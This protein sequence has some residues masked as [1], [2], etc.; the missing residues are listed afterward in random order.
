MNRSHLRA[1]ARTNGRGEQYALAGR[2]W[3]ATL[4]MIMPFLILL[5]ILSIYKNGV[6]CNVK[7][8]V[9]LVF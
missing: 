3:P 8:V 6:C 9:V 4:C 1:S 5:S 2:I 7:L